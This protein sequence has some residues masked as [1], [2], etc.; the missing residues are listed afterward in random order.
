MPFATPL[1]QLLLPLTF[2]C[3]LA[4]PAG[5]GTTSDPPSDGVVGDGSQPDGG[6]AALLDGAPD[7]AKDGGVTK[8]DGDGSMPTTA[9]IKTVFLILM[10][11]HSWSTI[12]AAGASATYIN[13]TLVPMGAHAE[14]Y[15]TPTSNH[16]SEPNY[17]WLEAGDNLGITN[18]NAPSA[19]HQSTKDH[20]TA[21]LET[22][23]ISWKAYAEDAP[24]STC[25]LTASG[26]YDPKHTP[27]LYFDDVTDTNKASSVYCQ[28]HVKPLTELAT[29][30]TA[31]K[32][33]RYNFITPNLCNDMHGNGFSG[34][35]SI[36]G[37]DSGRIKLGD[38]WLAAHV[39]QILASAAYKDNGVLFI[40]WDEGDES[41]FPPSS[42]DGPIGLIALSPLAKKGY[43]S[44]TA[45]T[46]SSMLRTV[47]TIFGV[48]FLRAAQTSNDLSELFT[49]F[50]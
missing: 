1:R 17:V 27:Q 19:N 35:C 50:P 43:A 3:A 29:D 47:E 28:D 32:V 41:G 8:P 15:L 9:G 31:D 22:K 5:C 33:A 13:G 4:A 10:E 2:A 44:N 6:G 36:V 25:P 26:L 11:N 21:Q 49:A 46:H 45:F 40:L 7:P 24:S 37:N 12:K 20:L 18:D 16:P 34:A 48:S 30:L 39:P 14:A 38:D 23:K 42:S